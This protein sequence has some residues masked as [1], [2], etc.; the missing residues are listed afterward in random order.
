[1]SEGAAGERACVAGEPHPADASRRAIVRDVVTAAVAALATI[2]GPDRLEAV[3]FS[4][5]RPAGRTATRRSY[6]VP[7]A[8]A[9][10]I[11]RANAVILVRWRN[12]LYAFALSSPRRAA[13]LG[14]DPGR[15]R[16]RCP[17]RRSRYDRGGASGSRRATGGTSRY[18][19]RREGE[20]VTVDLDRLYRQDGDRA[21]WSAAL[22]RL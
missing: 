15:G 17:E 3:P 20:C 5:T 8:D 10:Q 18:A 9:V 7:A 12:E 4:W 16:F 13:A 19:V 14:S 21:G 1:M 22:I 2:C 6:A 11:D